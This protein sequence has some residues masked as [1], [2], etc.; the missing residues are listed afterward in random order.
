M[1]EMESQV[2]IFC[3]TFRLEGMLDQNSS[4][5]AV[6]VTHPHPLYGGDMDNP[7]VMTIA[8]AFFEKGFTTLRFNFRG[9]GNSTGAFDNGNGEQEDIRAA[10]D[11]LLGKGFE[12]IHLA[13]YS[14]GSR[15]NATLISK[16]CQVEDHIMVS[17]PVA[18]MSFDD[19]EQMPYTGLIVTGRNDEIA[20]PDLIEKHIQG[21]GISPR[22]DI[23]EHCDHFYSG[24][25]KKLKIILTDYLSGKGK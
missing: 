25:L 4:Q 20:P 21:W 8:G 6:I 15:M 19:I 24:S 1:D 14:F 9:T 2:T 12:K 13:G 5:K 7:V 18:F 3:K 22:F 23:V 11:F 17:P 16:G 10:M